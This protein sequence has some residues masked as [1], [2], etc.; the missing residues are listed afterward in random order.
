M[1]AYERLKFLIRKL[2]KRPGVK[3]YGHD[4]EMQIVTTVNSIWYGG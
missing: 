1:K 4:G 2:Q 3:K